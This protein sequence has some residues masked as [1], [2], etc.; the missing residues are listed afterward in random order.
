MG[1]FLFGCAISQSFTDIAKVSV[2]RMRPH[3]ID[4]C[5]PD[6]STIDCTQGYI[7]NYTCTG[8]DSEVQEARFVQAPVTNTQRREL[9]QI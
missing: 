1:V 4:V 9:Y 6:F 2:G 3:F 5:K 7:T 8:A